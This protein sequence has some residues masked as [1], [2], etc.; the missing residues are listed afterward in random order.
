MSGLK[1]GRENGM[2]WSEIVWSEIWKAGRH[3]PTTNSE[4]YQYF[5]RPCSLFYIYASC[6][7]MVSNFIYACKTYVIG[8]RQWKS[9]LTHYMYFNSEASFDAMSSLTITE[10]QTWSLKTVSKEAPIYQLITYTTMMI[11]RSIV[12]EYI[13]YNSHRVDPLYDKR[14]EHI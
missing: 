3:T 11:V 5:V 4:E 12:R 1:T 2:F 6:S 14:P 7:Y 13:M 8:T 10:T 9:S